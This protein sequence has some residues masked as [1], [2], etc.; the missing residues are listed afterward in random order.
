MSSGIFALRPG[1]DVLPNSVIRPKSK[2][3]L[4]LLSCGEKTAQEAWDQGLN[5]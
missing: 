3:E 2:A 5:I 4:E 1:I